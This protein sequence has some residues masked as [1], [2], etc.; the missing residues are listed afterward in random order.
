MGSS[1]VEEMGHVIQEERIN[2]G[3]SQGELANSSEFLIQT[4]IITKS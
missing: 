3:I 2:Q 4:Y 1:F